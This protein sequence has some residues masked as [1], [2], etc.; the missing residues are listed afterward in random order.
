ME[1]IHILPMIEL[2]VIVQQ[3]AELIVKHRLLK[4]KLDPMDKKKPSHYLLLVR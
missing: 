4:S 3:Q 2:R 1:A